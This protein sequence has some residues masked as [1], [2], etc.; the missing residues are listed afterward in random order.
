MVE[1]I[2]KEVRQKLQDNSSREARESAERFFKQGEKALVY[3]V[4]S[5]VVRKLSKDYYKQI[6]ALPKESIFEMCEMLWQS[7]YLEEAAIAFQWSESLYKK[8]E[9]S[10]FTTFENWLDKYVDNWASCDGFCNHTVGSFVMMYPEHIT[11][12]KRWTSSPNRWL[13]RGA[14]VSLIIPAKKGMF[15]ND[16]FDIA[17]RLLLDPEDLVQKGYGWMLKVA[18]QPYQK[19]VFEYM[20]SKKDVMPRTA[21]RYAIEKM[22]TELRQEV[23]KKD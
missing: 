10:D 15:L 18:S 8:Y 9:P 2:V 3:G 4:K 1:N 20:M 16:I 11:E 7:H 12:L 14:A 13:R 22:P 23:M 6:K 5:P 21:L 17:D 19:A